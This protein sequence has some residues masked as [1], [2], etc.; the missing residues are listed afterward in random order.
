MQYMLD[1][2]TCIY[3]IKEQPESVQRRLQQVPMGAVSISSIVVAELSYGVEQSSRTQHNREALDEFLKYTLIENWP[4]EASEA[5]GKIRAELKSRG[6]PIGAMDLLVAAH[7]VYTRS[8]LV[9]DNLREFQ[10]VPGLKVENW[11]V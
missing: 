6:N 8:I 7:S 10:R 4:A 1:T 9:T 11:K 2:N 5:Y 3:I